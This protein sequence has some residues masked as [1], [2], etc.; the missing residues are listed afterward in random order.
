MTNMLI[1]GS[2]GFVGSRFV[3][4]SHKR[5]LNLLTPSHT[6]LDILNKKT[7]MAQV[8]KYNPRVIIN[9]CAI[10]NIDASEKE[11]GNKRGKTWQTNVMGV[12]HLVA[13]CKETGTFFIQISTDAVFPGSKKNHGPYHEDT[14]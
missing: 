14:P 7:I 6:T 1:I 8:K 10:T 3:E 2:S 12:A 13:A 4:L 9:F 11:R 5:P